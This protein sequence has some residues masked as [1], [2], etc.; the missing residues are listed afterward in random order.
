MVAGVLLVGQSLMG[1]QPTAV[2]IRYRLAVEA[3][4]W[5]SLTLAYHRDGSLFKA[6]R[7][8]LE[9]GRDTTLRHE[10]ELM[11][12]RYDIEVMVER[13]DGSTRE[14]SRRLDVPAD[15][16]VRIN[17]ADLDPR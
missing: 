15:G 12:G 13:T 3:P 1:A 16:V 7:F 5:T 14:L 2:D 9:P 8:H 11:P 10:V 6:A 17:L 4:Q